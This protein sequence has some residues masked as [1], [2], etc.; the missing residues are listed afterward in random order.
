MIYYKDFTK[1]IFG[2]RD[3]S[4]ANGFEIDKHVDCMDISFDNRT[5]ALGCD[6]LIK[7]YSF[8]HSLTY[9]F[10]SK[11]VVYLRREYKN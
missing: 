7:L 5:L 11:G 10:D 9:W 8:D 6:K 1:L 3:M 2:G 4:K